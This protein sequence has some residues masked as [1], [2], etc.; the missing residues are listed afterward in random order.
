MKNRGA[1]GHN[2]IKNISEVL[3]TP[4]YARL[5]IGVGGAR[6][7]GQEGGDYV[8]EKFNE[9]ESKGLGV[10]FDKCLEAIKSFI[11]KG[12]ERTANVYNQREPEKIADEKSEKK[13]EKKDE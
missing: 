11:E 12:Y 10:V 2:G 8:L 7:P 13:P 4:D 1:G 6:H 5:K 9:E 3:G